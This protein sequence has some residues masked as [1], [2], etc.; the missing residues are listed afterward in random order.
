MGDTLLGQ[1]LRGLRRALPG[2]LQ[3]G[4][5][6]G[7]VT[8]PFREHLPGLPGPGQPVRRPLAGPSSRPDV[9]GRVIRV[10][11]A[12]FLAVEQVR[13]APPGADLG[14]QRLLQLLDAHVEFLQRAAGSLGGAR[15]HLRAV[16]GHQV[17]GHQAL[18][19]AYRQDLYEQAGERVAVPAHEAGDGRVVNGLVPG[20]HPAANVIEAGHLHGPR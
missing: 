2:L 13:L 6:A 4:H 17:N 14:F 10:R 15:L 1:P 7:G 20:D 8:V 19:G 3:R 16:A 18:P 12:V 11:L 9:A 5:R